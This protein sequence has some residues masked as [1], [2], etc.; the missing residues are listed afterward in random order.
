MRALIVMAVALFVASSASADLQSTVGGKPLTARN[1]HNVGAGYPG[2]FYEWWHNS[3]ALDW[4]LTLG[5]VYGDWHGGVERNRTRGARDIIRLGGELDVPLRW[6]LKTSRRGKA[7]TA[8]RLTPGVLVADGSSGALT[9]GIRAEVAFPVSI[10]VNRKFGLVTGATIPF[11]YYVIE[12][13]SPDGFAVPIY[14]RFGFEFNAARRASPWI[15]FDFGPDISVFD[16]TAD[17]DF[18][19]R[20]WFGTSF[21]SLIK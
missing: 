3:R 18:G 9:I 10:R 11:T 19:F 21:W 13:P 5:L 17:V 14:A 12:N 2:A 8:F 1:V 20:I 4:G 7:Y 6:H 15:L 16:R